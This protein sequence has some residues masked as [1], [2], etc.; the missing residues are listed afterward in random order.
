M[1]EIFNCDYQTTAKYGARSIWYLD[2]DSRTSTL[3]YTT[4]V[5]SQLC[6]P[7]SWY[8]L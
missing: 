1:K 2:Q 5:W 7:R 6:N 8:H 3:Y 4:P